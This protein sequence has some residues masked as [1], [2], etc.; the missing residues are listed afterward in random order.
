MARAQHPMAPAC[1]LIHGAYNWLISIYEHCQS[2]K[3]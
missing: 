2:I 3:R 1:A